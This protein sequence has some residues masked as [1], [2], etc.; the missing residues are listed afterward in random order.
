[1]NDQ[2]CYDDFLPPTYDDYCDDTYVTKSSDK[3]FVEFAPTII[4]EKNFAYVKSSKFSMLVDHE[5]MLYVMV[6]L[7]NSFMILLKLL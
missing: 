4:H 7:L 5:K 3:Y 1:M 2:I 6:I